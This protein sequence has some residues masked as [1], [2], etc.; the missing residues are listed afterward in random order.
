MAWEGR[1]RDLALTASADHTDP[2]NDTLGN[3]NY[4]KLL[5]RRAQDVLRLGADWRGGPWQ[6]GATLAAFSERQDNAANTQ[7]LGG[8]A[9]LDLRAEWAATREL[10]VGLKLNNA[11]GKRYE[12]SLGY[13]QPGREAFVTLRYTPK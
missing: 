8:Y 10:A 13:D 4:G 9:T 1:W 7:R 3:A 12:T 2:R 6:A 5:P 11:G